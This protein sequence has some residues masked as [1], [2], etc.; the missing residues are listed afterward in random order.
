MAFVIY[1]NHPLLHYYINVLRVVLPCPVYSSASGWVDGISFVADQ[2][3][4]SIFQKNRW[5]SFRLQICDSKTSKSN[6][7]EKQ[8]PIYWNFFFNS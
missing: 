5:L 6:T 3:D 4:L 2:A 8:E 7:P 1:F